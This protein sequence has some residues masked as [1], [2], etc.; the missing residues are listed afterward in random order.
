M[1][2]KISLFTMVALLVA[3]SGR[4]LWADDSKKAEEVGEVKSA[5]CLSCAE[6]SASVSKDKVKA[7]DG[8]DD[9]LPKK[10]EAKEAKKAK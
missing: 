7:D 5:P 9:S 3:L 6:R 2:D 10:Q 1:F 8:D 4:A